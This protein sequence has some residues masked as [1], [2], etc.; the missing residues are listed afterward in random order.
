[1]ALHGT[2]VSDASLAA[3]SSG[4]DGGIVVAE[5]A[6][7]SWVLDGGVLHVYD[8]VD[9]SSA[10]GVLIAKIDEIAQASFAGVLCANAYADDPL[11]ARLQE[12][13]FEIDWDE[14]EVRGG[15]PT[16]IVGLVRHIVDS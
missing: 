8:I 11:L 9:R 3:R 10:L 5:G 2:T 1:L 16:R 4:D 7:A 13:G 15:H 12:Q 6:C 14:P